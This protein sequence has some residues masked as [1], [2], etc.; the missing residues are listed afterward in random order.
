MDRGVELRQ[1]VG[2]G[3][4][5]LRADRELERAG[6]IAIRPLR[7]DSTTVTLAAVL[8]RQ[9]RVPVVVRDYFMH[10]QDRARRPMPAQTACATRSGVVRSMS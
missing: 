7:D 2:Q 8:R 5:P 1:A 6:L 10:L 4:R 3:H 9:T